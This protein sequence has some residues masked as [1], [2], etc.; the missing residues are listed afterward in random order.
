MTYG[1]C[2]MIRIYQRYLSPLLPGA[3]RYSPTCSQYAIDAIQR[4]G[5]GRG[6]WLAIRRLLRCRP[7]PGGGSG[8][9]P[10]G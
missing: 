4:H 7:G 1:L 9:D 2:A 3:C 6:S 8:F 10:V 5:P